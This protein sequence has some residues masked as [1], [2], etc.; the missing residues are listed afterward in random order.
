LPLQPGS[1]LGHYD[2]VSAL[3]AGGMGE[4]YRARDT[5]LKRDVAIKVLPEPFAQDADRLARFQREAELLA[6]LNHPNVAAVY[7][8]EKSGGVTGIVLEL[9]EGETLADVI[10]RGPIA[11]AEAL[12]I[13]RQIA[14]ALD[15]AHE[16][17]VIHRD[18]KP[19]NIKVTPDGK[20]KVLDFGLAKMLETGRPGDLGS[21]GGLSPTFSP[22][23]SVHATDAGV[24]LGTAAY[25]SPE[26][27]RGKPVDRRTDIW[28][29]GCVFYEMLSGRK[30]FETG[31]TVSD[32]IAAILKTD[33]DWTAL[34]A[35]VPDQIRLL[36]KRCLEKDRAARIGEI[37]TVR[38]LMIE[39]IAPASRAPEVAA[40]ARRGFALAGS[41]GIVAGAC[42][43]TGIAWWL[44]HSAAPAKIQPVRFSVLPSAALS[45]T[46]SNADREV[47][48][49]PDGTHI[50]WVAGT[51]VGAG[52]GGQLAV[53]AIDQVE[54]TPLRGIEGARSPFISPDGKWIAYFDGSNEL[55]KVSISG[56]PP[57]TV[58]RT[59]SP[60]RG[61]SWGQD[62]T[63][64]FATNDESTGLFS[65]SAGGGDPKILSR[66]DTAH[67]E[68]DH[69]FPSMLPGGGAVLYTIR[70]SGG[71][72]DNSQIAALDLKTG[73]SKTLIRGG[74]QAEYVELWPGS[75]SPGLL[76]YA[77]AGALRAV[78]F[79]PVTLDVLSDPTLV[80][81]QVAM[82]MAGAAEYAVSRSG[83]LVYVPAGT[84]TFAPG[85]GVLRTLVWTDRQGREDAIPAPPRAYV[86][87]RLSP[88]GAKIAL[89]ARDQ[90]NDIW[91]FDLARKTLAR[92]TSDNAIDGFPVWTPD[93]RRI[94]F[95]SN[96]TGVFNLYSQAAD[97]TGGV[98][99]LTK[100]PN[101][102]WPFSMSPD[103]T[104]A[105]LHETGVKTGDDL[106]VLL[107]D[108]KSRPEP[109]IQTT[110]NEQHGELSPDG[111]WI[112]YD[113][114]DAGQQQVFVR[115]F[116]NVN[117]G[118]WLVSPGGGSKP[119]WAHSGR[120]LFYFSGSAMMAVPVQT[121]S[122]FVAGN[123]V[124]LFDGA[125][126]SAQTPR[127]YDVD[128]SDQRFLMIK[129]PPA[130]VDPATK[131]A[132]IV[133]VL[134]WFEELKPRVATAR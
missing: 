11:Y 123:A 86:S 10:A 40:P 101:D 36:L 91:I 126:Y 3:G 62:D 52:G 105:I 112:A 75:A 102:I 61:G 83:A 65:V 115:P 116:P 1:R 130:V 106:D 68:V 87:L 80:V 47:V 33:V 37:G 77:A 94:L 49:S 51:G 66:A 121:T 78:R 98:E 31:E 104:R 28:A 54:A 8:L 67:G 76:V 44:A 39:T 125:Y 17:G 53:R 134:N 5:Q 21:P 124:R 129:D 72:A 29:F 63:I 6:T 64:V 45:I 12:P 19:A 48:I 88:D 113:S 85:G 56:G 42:V 71:G 120:E 127:V 69:W 41:L 100:S 35:D 103:G 57:I 60:P 90:N 9:V 89:D 34:P 131:P 73:R 122:G 118:H 27:A 58:C 46:P 119:V 14:D 55:R 97:G 111:R 96:R 2:I 59:G 133:V 109:L 25:M 79:D 22:T 114:N 23:L 117:G 7:G 18:L 108:G 92:L 70:P 84:T 43:A 81:D 15:A 32:A 4:V 16:R 132:T 93:G 110:F 20:V 99:V 13:A 74:T 38:F 50:V 107:L 24:I 128:R 30:V 82:T 95:H 26:Q